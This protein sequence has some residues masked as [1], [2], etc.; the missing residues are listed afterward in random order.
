[1]RSIQSGYYFQAEDYDVYAYY[2]NNFTNAHQQ[3]LK[4]LDDAEFVAYL[5]VG[6]SVF[7][8]V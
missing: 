7:P 2:A 6:T 8:N 1:M 3:L 4:L 5:E